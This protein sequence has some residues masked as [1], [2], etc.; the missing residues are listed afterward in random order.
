MQPEKA[1]S[2]PRPREYGLPAWLKDL[3]YGLI[4]MLHWAI[5]KEID[6]PGRPELYE[7]LK[8]IIDAARFLRQEM[9]DRE[10]SNLLLDGDPAFLN[11]NETYHGLGDL[12][13]RC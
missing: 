7:R 11:Q 13:D 12:V 3:P 2:S 1:G 8:V 4:E 5:E 10:M 9:A 6:Y